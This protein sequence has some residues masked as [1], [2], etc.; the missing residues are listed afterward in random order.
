M[1][2]FSTE[3]VLVPFDFSDE[4]SKALTNAV[5]FVG[6]A[7]RLYVLHVLHRLE[8]T[9]PSIVWQ[10]IDDNTR[11]QNVE[12]AF[13]EKFDPALGIHFNVAIGDPGSEILDFA[14]K[15]DITLIVIPS[16]GRTGLGRFFL[17][18]VAERVMRYAH[19]PVLVLRR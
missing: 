1:G 4:A 2:L 9:E 8:S 6:D 13:S 14:E 16:H 15:N 10:T 7:S 3:R 11:R 5:E 19:C 18:S 12:K 17:G